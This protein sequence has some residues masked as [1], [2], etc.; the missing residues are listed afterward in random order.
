[1][2]NTIISG[3]KPDR[4]INDNTT[5]M[6]AIDNHGAGADY[7][8]DGNT[9]AFNTICDLNN[10][11]AND[12]Y[13]A[14][15]RAVFATG[16]LI[17]GNK[18]F[19]VNKSRIGGGIF[20]S[21]SVDGATVKDNEIRGVNKGIF[22]DG[23]SNSTNNVT[24]ESN[25]VYADK[26]GLLIS[27]QEGGGK[28]FRIIG[29]SVRVQAAGTCI[30]IGS[31]ALEAP[32]IAFNSCDGGNES[33]ILAGEYAAVIGNVARNANLRSY[34][35]RD[36]LA[37]IGNISVGAGTEDYVIPSGEPLPT[38]IGNRMSNSMTAGSPVIAYATAIPAAGQWRRGDRVYHA[39][40]VPGGPAGWICTSGGTPGTWKAFGTIEV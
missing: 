3:G 4:Y 14:A 1:M 12:V 39:A 40:P 6:S 5:R 15:I 9:I 38:W 26:N 36:E 30:T 27:M 34:R 21:R 31:G 23:N 22:T 10:D 35:I 37:F 18:I 33:V 25:L 24:I 32:I 19:G 11:L 16:S 2:G 7:L 29:N 28:Q 13:E 20:I 8:N 17:T